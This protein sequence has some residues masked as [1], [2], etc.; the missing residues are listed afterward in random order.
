LKLSVSFDLQARFSGVSCWLRCSHAGRKLNQL[1][2]DAAM[3]MKDAPSTERL[4]ERTLGPVLI[5][6]IIKKWGGEFFYG[7]I[8]FKMEK[9]VSL[10]YSTQKAAQEKFCDMWSKM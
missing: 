1:C 5:I 4:H 8:D 2:R 3:T 9:N 6:F 7:E 10:F